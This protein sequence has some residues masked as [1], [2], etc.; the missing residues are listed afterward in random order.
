[1]REPN[2]FAGIDELR[3]GLFSG[4]F[5]PE[6]LVEES[7][8][9]IELVQPQLNCFVEVWADQARERAA[10]LSGIDAETRQA[11]PLHAIPIAIKDTTP[12]LGQRMSQG[13]LTQRHHVADR[14]ARVVESLLRAG[15]I[16]VGS[17]NTPEFAHASITDNRLWG[18]TLNPWDTTRSPGGSSGG[19]GAAVASGCVVLAEGSDMGGSVRIPAAWCGVS[20]LKPSLGRI[21]MDALPGLWDTLS[22]HGP[23]ARRVDDIWE[24]LLATQGPSLADPWSNLFPLHDSRNSQRAADLRVGL[25]M[26]LGCWAVNPE[27]M[28]TIES[29]ATALREAG[30]RVEIVDLE[31][32]AEDAE[33]WLAMWSVFMAGYF[34]HLVDES[35]ADLDVDVV[36]LIEAG[37]RMSA[38]DYKRLELRR[39][40][41]W[42]RVMDTFRSCDVIMCPTMAQAP[43]PA[44]KAEERSRTRPAQDGLFHA[45]D[46]TSVWNLVAPC[47]AIS[48]PGGRFGPGPDEG[49]PIGVQFIGL[50][51]REDHILALAR[52]LEEWSGSPQWRPPLTGP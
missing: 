30:V 23:L 52:C 33:L 26:D 3:S 38:A 51:G 18:P 40:L 13:S 2:C 20:G 49:L 7:L 44:T 21:P 25:S 36:R 39:T 50:P 10:F 17:T 48:V 22:H 15:A 19:A 6:D 45:D 1:M 32:S 27:I 4:A 8:A 46:M 24:F 5:S 43:K 28:T 41:V 34:G 14:T 11:Q 29:A 35:R 42:N 9:R 31:F 47:P 16:I 37:S 12:W